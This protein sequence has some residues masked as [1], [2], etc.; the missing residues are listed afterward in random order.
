M[1][2][3]KTQV[4]RMCK[5]CGMKDDLRKLNEMGKA[6]LLIPNRSQAEK[7]LTVFMFRSR[8]VRHR[9]M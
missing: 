4:E 2:A 9:K 3:E 6:A 8:Y 7:T 1:I 5:E